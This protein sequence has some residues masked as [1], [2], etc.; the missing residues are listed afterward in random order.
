M[1]SGTFFGHFSGKDFSE[2]NI[3][4]TKPS[5]KEVMD[6]KDDCILFQVRRIVSAVTV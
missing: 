1:A 2:G 6:Y 4:V 5:V 3:G